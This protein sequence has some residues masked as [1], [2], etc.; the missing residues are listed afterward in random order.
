MD[1]MPALPDPV[2]SDWSDVILRHALHWD[3]GAPGD[4]A[5][6]AWIVGSKQPFSHGGMDAVAADQH[7]AGDGLAA[8]RDRAD[9]IA[10]LLD[11]RDL[12][13]EANRDRRGFPD[14]SF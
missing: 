9:T 6:E 10:V 8:C 3:R 2:G 11:P 4:A 14:G 5:G 7:I 13:I 12:R 1:E